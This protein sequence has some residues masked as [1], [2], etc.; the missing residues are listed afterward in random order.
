MPLSKI[1]AHRIQRTS[2]TDTATLKLHDKVWALNGKVEECFRELKHAM[3][4]RLGKDYG[5][6]S[7]DVGSHPLSS[8]LQEYTEEKLSFE[9]A[10][11]K[12]MGHLKNELDKTEEVIDCF[13]FFAHETQEVAEYIHIFFAQHHA[14]VFLDGDIKLNDSLYL[15]TSDIRLAA[16]INLTDWQSG[17]NYKVANTLTLLRARGEKELSDVFL[18]FI[19]FSEKIDIRA[20]TEEFL[21]VVT[22]YT[23]DLPEDVAHHTKKQVVNYC[24]E[25]NK[26]GKPVAMDELS[27]ELKDNPASRA[28]IV[29]TDEETGEP[30]EIAPE[31]IKPLPEFSHFISNSA[32]AT[33]SNF[34]PDSSQLKQFVR[35]SGRNHQLSMSFASSCLGDSIVYDAETDSLIIKEIPTRLKAHLT[36]HLEKGG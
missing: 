3:I 12:A 31:P 18:T 21:N 5:R 14:A 20:D 2:P 23:K 27:Q 34:I 4:K 9:S 35:L 22:D 36:K 25:Q 10:S 30:I 11:Q 19:G 7:D 17:D 16:K 28:P 6:F 33:K 29:I 13:V 15:D 8:W 26:M 24:I 1:I 32:P